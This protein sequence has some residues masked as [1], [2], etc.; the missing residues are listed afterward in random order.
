MHQPGGHVADRARRGPGPLEGEEAPS[1]NTQDREEFSLGGKAR[2]PH[3]L[4]V[5][6]ADEAAPDRKARQL[7][8]QIAGDRPVDA[9]LDKCRI[10]AEW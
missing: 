9:R 3:L 10:I 5:A 7:A 2:T 4:R 1:G 6:P 8:H